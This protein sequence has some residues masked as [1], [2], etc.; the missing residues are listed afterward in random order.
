MQP[1]D[2]TNVAVPT[3]GTDAS[4]GGRNPHARLQSLD[5][6]RG[7]IMIGLS[8]VGFGLYGTAQQHLQRNPTHR[9]GAS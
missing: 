4:A 2:T 9:S 6:Y 1:Q 7:L 3:D 8:F 5:A